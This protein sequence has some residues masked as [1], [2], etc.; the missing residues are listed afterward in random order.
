M[1]KEV[2]T[3]VDNNGKAWTETVDT[4]KRRCK[5]RFAR[6]WFSI[7]PKVGEY[8]ALDVWRIFEANGWECKRFEI[9]QEE[10]E[11]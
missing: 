9:I 10:S 5:I 7:L 11:N 1:I 4:D 8:E 3:I 2:F 6:E